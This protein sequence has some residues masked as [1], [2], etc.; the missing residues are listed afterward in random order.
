MTQRLICFLA[1]AIAY[2]LMPVAQAAQV[3]I[4]PTKD[5]TIFQN[6]ANNGSGSGNGLFAGNNG[7]SSP[8]RA[9]VT[10]D[11]AGSLPPNATVTSVQL[12]LTLGMTAG[13]AG[14][15]RTVGLH[16]V[17]ADWGEGDT[18]ADLDPNSM[19]G[20]GSGA[21]AIDGDV[22]WN[23]RFHN[24]APASPWAA[25]GGVFQSTASASKLVGSSINSVY[26]WSST[27]ELVSDVQLWYD[28]PAAN[29]GWLLKGDESAATTF[30]AF[31]SRNVE[32]AAN[33]PKL[34]ITYAV[35]EPAG[36]LLAVGALSSWA[37]SRRGAMLG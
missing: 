12:A 32:T 1:A 33:R 7:M 23:S 3:T 21:P 4:E 16:R 14:G 5:A 27:A 17:G 35:P 19:S 6:P 25:A 9:L 8:R 18:L 26:N 13:G 28:S 15:G 37:L 10:F 24:T 34:T 30:R 20:Q 36:V 11:V 22:T 31:Y 2:H 29:F